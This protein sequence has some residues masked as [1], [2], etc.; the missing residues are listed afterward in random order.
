MSGSGR[1]EYLIGCLQPDQKFNL[2]K[3]ISTSI[4]K[5]FSQLVASLN[6]GLSRNENN[7][8]DS[9]LQ[10]SYDPWPRQK[11][12]KNQQNQ[13]ND[14][15]K[16]D[17]DKN[18]K[19]ENFR[20]P[21]K[22]YFPH[23][24]SSDEI[25]LIDYN[26]GN[27]NNNNN[28]SNS[29]GYNDNNSNNNNYNNK[30]NY[31]QNNNNDNDKNG[32]YDRNNDKRNSNDHETENEINLSLVYPILQPQTPTRIFNTIT[33][34]NKKSSLSLFYNNYFNNSNNNS[35][36][37]NNNK[38]NDDNDNDNDNNNDDNNK[39]NS[40]KN[41]NSNN[42]TNN[43]NKNTT[44]TKKSKKVKGPF[45]LPWTWNESFV[46]FSLYTDD[47]TSF[48]GSSW[49]FAKIQVKDFLSNSMGYNDGTYLCA[50]VRAFFIEQL[51]YCYAIA[52]DIFISLIFFIIL[53]LSY[54]FFLYFSLF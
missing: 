26:S 45:F 36:R 8:N 43:K 17:G 53:F 28:N 25:D 22:P 51:A 54:L 4:D 34:T 40:E 23:K 18:G 11:I 19:N 31:T 35:N 49:G 47:P 33:T 1:K 16:N 21:H 5:S 32:N 12:E 2:E 7:T 41:T 44:E 37:N 20:S 42:N 13:K 6:L 14:G 48:L 29:N 38:K 50:Y 3:N 30:N 10:N 46:K 9:I 52:I 15:E 39:N 24:Q 27:Y